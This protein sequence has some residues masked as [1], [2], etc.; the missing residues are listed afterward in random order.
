[1]ADQRG[2]VM[3]DTDRNKKEEYLLLLL[4]LPF[5]FLYFISF[6]SFAQ[7]LEVSR[8]DHFSYYWVFRRRR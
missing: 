1:M 7:S 8:L 3:K 2:K 5:F 6:L 4:L